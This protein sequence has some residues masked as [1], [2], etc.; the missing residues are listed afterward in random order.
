MAHVMLSESGGSGGVRAGS[1][2]KCLA[3]LNSSKPDDKHM[4]DRS[5]A[6]L[7][8]VLCFNVLKAFWEGSST[9]T[10]ERCFCDD[11]LLWRRWMF[12][13]LFLPRIWWNDGSSISNLL[14]GGGVTPLIS[15]I[16]CSQYL[17]DVILRAPRAMSS[18]PSLWFMMRKFDMAMARDCENIRFWRDGSERDG[19]RP[20]TVPSWINYWVGP[21]H[22]NPI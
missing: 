21:G 18:L 6:L 15:S 17:V 10:K 12:L 19:I 5:F 16:C 8:N 9:H 7:Y 4:L 14:C 20:D 1:E 13:R 22:V 3:C 2:G 11:G